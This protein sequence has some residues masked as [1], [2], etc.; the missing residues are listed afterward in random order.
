[1]YDDHYEP[2]RWADENE[3]WRLAREAGTIDDEIKVLG[4]AKLK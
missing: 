1:L 4:D 2:L 3:R